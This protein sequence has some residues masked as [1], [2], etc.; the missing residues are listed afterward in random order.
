MKT[1][2]IPALALFVLGIVAFR[3]MVAQAPAFDE[4]L[5]VEGITGDTRLANRAAMYDEGSY[6]FQIGYGYV[7]SDALSFAGIEAPDELATAAVARARF[8]RAKSLLEESLSVDPA[9]AH[10]WMSYA[11]SLASTGDIEGAARA[12]ETSW[13]LAPTTHRLSV[14]RLTMIN[15]VRQSTGASTAYEDIVRSDT[16]ALEY[17]S[18]NSTRLLERILQ[19]DE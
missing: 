10:A 3:A 12:M 7:M 17:H 15:L 9:N 2:A 8:Q 6:L 4:E 16:A 5:Q 18:P 11:Q 13:Q 19:R 1:P 14:P